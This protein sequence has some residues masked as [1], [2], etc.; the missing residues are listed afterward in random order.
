[1]RTRVS[2]LTL[3]S[4]PL[5]RSPFLLPAYGAIARH[6]RQG[7]NSITLSGSPLGIPGKRREEGEGGTADEE[8]EG[9]EGVEE[10]GMSV[11]EG[12]DGSE[13]DD[14]KEAEEN[15]E[16]GEM[17][18]RKVWR[19]GCGARICRISLVPGGATF[20]RRRTLASL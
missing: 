18:R 6:I 10:E 12:K 14:D 4:S 20:R 5:L 15:A 7:T 2:D 3:S 19:A 16:E 13:E 17:T 8:N 11:H 1:M 9:I